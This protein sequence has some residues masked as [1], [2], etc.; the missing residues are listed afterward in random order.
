[1]KTED[2]ITRFA[3]HIEA[4]RRL[5]E[6]TVRYYISVSNNLVQHLLSQ[7]INDIEEINSNDIRTWLMGELE[8]G[9]KSSTVIKQTAALRAF[10]KFLLKKGY[11]DHDIMAKITPPKSAKKLPIFFRET[12]VEK[13]YCDIYPDTFDGETH[14]MVLRLLYET[15]MR[16]SE[17]ASLTLAS[18]DL[19]SLTIKVRGKRNKE[20]IIPIEKEMANNISR[21]ITL[22]KQMLE[23]LSVEKPE[24]EP[25]ERLLVNGKGKAVSDGMI[26]TIVE[27]YMAANSNAD[28]TSPH[29][30]RHTFATHMLNEGANIDAIKE[31]L[32]HSDLNATEV[33]THVT[34]E[35]LK[36]TYKHAHPRATKNKEV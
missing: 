18:I 6:G 17:L 36:E 14:K 7:G 27:R 32:G 19:H 21:Y 35:H 33:Y 20:R 12:E 23:S 31:L 30:F 5:A 15:G 4:E 29:V 13:I 3:N 2:A 25:T 26:Y 9:E 11:L 16:R 24:F 10:F 1:M 8:R 22:R 34:R 28:R